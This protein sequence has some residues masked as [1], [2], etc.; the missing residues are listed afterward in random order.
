MGA[1]KER[2][3]LLILFNGKLNQDCFRDI[4]ISLFFDYNVLP[5]DKV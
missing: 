5:K 4:L 3:I 2:Q 1:M